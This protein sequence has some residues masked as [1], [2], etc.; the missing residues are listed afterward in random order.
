MNNYIK[1]MKLRKMAHEEKITMPSRIAKMVDEALDSL[2]NRKLDIRRKLTYSLQLV[3]AMVVA[4]FVILPNTNSKVAYAM[5]EIP[6]IGSL[7]KIVTIRNYSEENGNSELNIKIPK[8]KNEDNSNSNANDEINENVEDLTQEI[9]QQY[10]SEE[11]KSTKLAVSIDSEVIRNDEDWFTLKLIISRTMADTEKEYKYY[12]LNKKEDKIMQLSDLFKNEKYKD[13]IN[14][15]IKK[16]MKSQMKSDE[17]IIYWTDENKFKSISD[18]QNYYFSNNGNIVIVFDQFEVA[19]GYM[20]NP[21][22][23]ILKNVYEGYLKD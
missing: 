14:E 20:G 11:G 3:M 13:S 2:P 5:S 17:N 1:S 9:L 22:F 21:E 12:N 15:E 8:V 7:A 18:D 6:V 4:I 10:Y 16:Q 23:E 19:P